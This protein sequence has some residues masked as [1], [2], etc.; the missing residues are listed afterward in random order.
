MVSEVSE[1]VGETLVPITQNL[2][3]VA[4]N[5]VFFKL[6]KFGIVKTDRLGPDP[7]L[8]RLG[9]TF[10]HGSIGGSRAQTQSL[11]PDNGSYSVTWYLSEFS[12]F[13]VG[14]RGQKSS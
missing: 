7:L 5:N 3:S 1:R 11:Y 13:T 10:K 4:R 2:E 12:E 6:K 14:G 8:S 9:R